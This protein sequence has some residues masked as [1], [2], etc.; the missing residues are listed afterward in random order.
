M[1]STGKA[2]QKAA[3]TGDDIDLTERSG[4]RDQRAVAQ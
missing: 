2:E 3:I 4:G 1:V